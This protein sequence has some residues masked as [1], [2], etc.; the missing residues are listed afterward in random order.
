MQVDERAECD[1][2]EAHSVEKC[3]LRSQRPDR[4]DSIKP[5]RRDCIGECPSCRGARWRDASCSAIGPGLR[6]EIGSFFKKIP[7]AQH[8][9]PGKTDICSAARSCKRCDS[10]VVG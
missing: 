9:A 7:P 3:R 10:E 2:Q 1:G 4:L 5:I 6:E 8:A